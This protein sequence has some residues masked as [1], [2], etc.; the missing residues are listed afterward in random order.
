VRVAG[1][2]G[3]LGAVAGLV[4]TWLAA[5]PGETPPRLVVLAVASCVLTLL[6]IPLGVRRHPRA[7]VLLLLE[8]AVGL[9]IGIGEAALIPDALLA[10]AALLAWLDG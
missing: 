7:L 8:G 6:G 5:V 9:W 10:L 2:L 4:A 1:L 3:I